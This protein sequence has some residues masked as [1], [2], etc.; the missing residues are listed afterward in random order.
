MLRKFCASRPPLVANELDN[1]DKDDEPGRLL[2]NA[3]M[4]DSSARRL[5]GPVNS[6]GDNCDDEDMDEMVAV[7]ASLD[8]D[9]SE[10][11]LGMSARCG[12][13]T[14][15]CAASREA[16]EDS[17]DKA[18]RADEL[19]GANE[20]PIAGDAPKR[21][22][23]DEANE[24]EAKL[25]APPMPVAPSK[26]EATPK[27]AGDADGGVV[28]VLGRAATGGCDGDVTRRPDDCGTRMAGKDQS[29]R[30]LSWP[31]LQ[32]TRMYR[33]FGNY[34]SACFLNVKN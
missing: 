5:R 25:V 31:V 7:A 14:E 33:R 9:D 24:D 2:A 15:R 3:S 19:S 22:A 4:V 23:D 8:R 6:D 26:R 27:R 34:L 20:A 1:T 13:V 30:N 18:D 16:D 10:L 17:D 11:G 28:P 12:G 32:W 21:G 29:S